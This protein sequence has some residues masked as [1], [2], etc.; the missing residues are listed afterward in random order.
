MADFATDIKATA[1][2]FR[3]AASE[4]EH[5]MQQVAWAA[6]DALEGDPKLLPQ[7]SDPRVTREQLAL[8]YGARTLAPA[9]LRTALEA[10]EDGREKIRRLVDKVVP[11]EVTAKVAPLPDAVL[12]PK[13]VAAPPEPKRG[14]LRRLLGV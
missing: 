3:S 13:P 2:S 1:E 5:L 12:V 4:L 11:P 8:E 7:A 9:A 10:L 6:Q 14:W